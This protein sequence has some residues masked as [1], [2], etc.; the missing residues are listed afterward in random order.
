MADYKDP[1]E[2]IAKSQIPW[3]T[4]ES[5]SESI[6]RSWVSTNKASYAAMNALIT[7]VSPEA[8]AFRKQLV[9]AIWQEAS[10]EYENQLDKDGN[11]LPVDSG[12]GARDTMARSFQATN[13]Q[14]YR[15][16]NALRAIL[17]RL[18][19]QDKAI[20]D[21]GKVL[22]AIAAKVGLPNQ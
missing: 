11:P 3:G 18:D 14:V 6:M 1:D 9:R 19:A 21:L 5:K 16:A 4:D 17:A 15:N 10:V 2:W 13:G 8:V 22:A 12:K 20:A 7:D